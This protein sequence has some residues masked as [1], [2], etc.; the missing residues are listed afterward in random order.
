MMLH[1]VSTSMIIG[2]LISASVSIKI[3]AFTVDSLPHHTRRSSNHQGIS[4]QL[5]ARSDRSRNVNITPQHSALAQVLANQ[6]GFDIS[7]VQPSSKQPGAKI[8][9]ADVEYHAWKISQPPCTSDALE[10]AYSLGLDLNELYD[11]D[12]REYV[13]NMADIQLYTENSRSLRMSSQVKKKNIDNEPTKKMKKMKALDKRVEQNV[14]KLTYTAMQAAMTVTDGIVQQVQSQILKGVQN[15]SSELGKDFMAD[16][17][18]KNNDE[19]VTVADFDLELAIEIQEALSIAEEPSMVSFQPDD[20]Q[21]NSNGA[22]VGDGYDME[23]L[24]SM[25]CTQLKDE[26]R[27]RGM[28]ISGKKAELV[29]RLLYWAD[30]V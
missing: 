23:E 4:F 29:D 15:S 8:T 1:T 27:Q 30:P 12:D 13:M 14:E 5:Q 20:Q 26:L 21:N 24:R 11:D 17:K 2:Y 3:A 18:D 7:A 19:I 10:V 22:V 28:K 6:Y 25:T 9:A 16:M